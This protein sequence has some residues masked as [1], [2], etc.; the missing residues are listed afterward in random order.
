LRERFIKYFKKI[1]KIFIQIQKPAS[2]LSLRYLY[3][4]K[5]TKIY[6]EKYEDIQRKIRRY[7]EKNTKI[8]REK[9]EDIQR[10]IPYL[11]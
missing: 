9:Y 6:R 8:Y 5:N 7:T 10:K 3:T 1:Y 2:E 11:S 4:E